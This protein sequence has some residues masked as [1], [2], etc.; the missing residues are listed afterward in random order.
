MKRTC[1]D[2]LGAYI[3]PDGRLRCL[4]NIPDAP[5]WVARV[6]DATDCPGFV[7]EQEEPKE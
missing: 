2:C 6:R 3:H 4:G 7:P 1:W 5:K